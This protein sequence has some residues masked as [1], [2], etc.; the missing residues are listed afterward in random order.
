MG[1]PAW[2]EGA[3]DVDTVAAG[4]ALPLAFVQLGAL[5]RDRLRRQVD[6][7]AP[8]VAQPRRL[9]K[10]AADEFWWSLP[11]RV[12]NSSELPVVVNSVEVEVP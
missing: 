3:A 10:G 1:V 7:V 5:R 9:D 8:W 6:R 11:L 12:R 2:L 4:L